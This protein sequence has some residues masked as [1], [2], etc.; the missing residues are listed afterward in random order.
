MSLINTIA[1]L[2]KYVAIDGNLKM[3]TIQPFIDE[4][5]QLYIVDLLGKAFYDEFKALYEASVPPTAPVVPLSADNAKL[6]PFIQRCL[7]YYTQLLAIPHLSVTFG[8]MGIRQHR[9]EDSDAAPRW[10]EDKLLFNALKNGDIHA[11]KL[12]EFLEANASVSVYATWF[13][14]TSNTKN[15]GY[16]IYGTAIASRHIAINNSRRVFLQ[17]RQKIRE[18]EKRIVPKMI[19]NDQYDELVTQLTTGNPTD[20]NKAL[21]E[22]IEPIICKRALFM[23]LPFMR[24]QINENGIFVYSGTDDVIK[25]AQLAG[26]ADIKILRQ[27]LMDG[28]ELGY[29]SDE[30]ALKQFILDNIDDYPLIKASGVYTVQPDPGPTWTAPE[31]DPN[32]KYFSV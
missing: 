6:L 21:I 30:S 1:E 26:D 15:S 14:S 23:Q 16:I 22:K 4:A 19:G 17:L 29:L 20:D 24:V 10:K 9:G 11:D 32:D 8:D 12:L 18:I 7:A 3:A 25:P 5:E 27:Q 28:E 31:P 2:K 13:A